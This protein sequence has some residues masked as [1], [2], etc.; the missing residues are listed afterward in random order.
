MN[1]L[2][3]MNSVPPDLQPFV[4]FFQLHPLVTRPEKFSET[5]ARIHELSL[6]AMNYFQTSIFEE[7]FL[8]GERFLEAYYDV[9]GDRRN[10]EVGASASGLIVD[11]VRLT[12]GPQFEFRTDGQDRS[13]SGNFS[14]N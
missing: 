6:F 14:N 3:P 10:P 7:H 9:L 4:S 1:Q 2:I 8:E 13:T 5:V 11:F 12:M